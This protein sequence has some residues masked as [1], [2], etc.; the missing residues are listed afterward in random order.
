M[1]EH[2]EWITYAENELKAAHHLL[3]SSDEAVIFPA[4]YMTQQ[5]AEKALKA[6]LIF[7]GVNPGKIHDLRDLVNKCIIYDQ[8]FASLKEHAVALN[9]YNL[10]TRYPD[11]FLPLPDVSVIIT[12]IKSAAFILEFVKE[13]VS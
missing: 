12:S 4:L 6:F 9:P 8:E 11:S 3:A 2:K 5:C 13:K 7:K 10:G 1:Q